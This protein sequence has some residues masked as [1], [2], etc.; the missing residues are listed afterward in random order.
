MFHDSEIAQTFQ[1]GRL[2]LSYVINFGLEPYLRKC[3]INSIND[4]PFSS[5]SF[6]ESFNEC[7][8]NCQMDLVLR[9]WDVKRKQTFVRYFDSQF[10]GHPNA[11]NLLALLNHS[12]DKLD[13]SNMTQLAIDG[14][15]TNFAL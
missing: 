13:A 10:L 15:S 8:K 14:P 3:L 4:S 5:I 7:F 11:K 2:K 6:D 12:V 9:F 1:M